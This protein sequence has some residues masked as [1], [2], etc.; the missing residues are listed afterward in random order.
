[1]AILRDLNEAIWFVIDGS[2]QV[3]QTMR[4]ARLG[5]AIAD[6]LF[7]FWFCQNHK[8]GFFQYLPL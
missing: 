4:G 1:M 8:G 2:E 5:E 6:L 3:A 7:I